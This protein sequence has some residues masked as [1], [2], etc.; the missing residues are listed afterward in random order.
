MGGKRKR[1]GKAYCRVGGGA[2]GEGTLRGEQ[3][4]GEGA[5]L[6]ENRRGGVGV[7]DVDAF[8]AAASGFDF[9][10]A[11][12]LIAR[13]VA[14][15]DE[16][17]GKQSSDYFLRSGFVEDEDSIDTFETSEY[18]GALALRY[19]RA[20]G[21]FEGANAAVTVN[22]DDEDIAKGACSFQAVDMAGM[23]KIEAAVGEDHFAAVAFLT[24]KL[25]NRLFQ[26][27]H[28]WMQR[29]S[30]NSRIGSVGF[31]TEKPVYHPGRERAHP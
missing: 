25:Q 12:D 15:F 13:P 17:I 3:G 22:P 24:G 5:D 31:Q 10:A 6:F 16:H 27:E 30:M 7:E 29:N 23:K 28:F 1:T 14:T 21:T 8:D 26:S 2:Q 4:S 18:L 20:P 9:F 11:D 19:N